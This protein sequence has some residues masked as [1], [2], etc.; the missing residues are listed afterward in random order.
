MPLRMEETEASGILQGEGLGKAGKQGGDFTSSLHGV[1][2]SRWWRANGK[3]RVG[4]LV[5]RIDALDESGPDITPVGKARAQRLARKNRQATGLF[6]SGSMGSSLTF[7]H[8]RTMCRY[9]AM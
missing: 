2:C 7:N 5:V 1:A 3:I 6:P 8:K 4:R 9:V